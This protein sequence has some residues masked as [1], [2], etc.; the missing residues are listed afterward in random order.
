MPGLLRSLVVVG[1]GAAMALALL[2][3]LVQ[4][5]PSAAEPAVRPSARALPAQ[6]VQPG[7]CDLRATTDHRTDVAGR[8]AGGTSARSCTT[9]L[10]PAPVVPEVPAPVLLPLSA[11]LVAL[12]AVFINWAGRH[13][14]KRRR[15]S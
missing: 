8:F 1:G 9:Q 6:G 3:L 7:T 12:I 13:P 2:V 11:G 14:E 4:P 10:G 15:G 5:G